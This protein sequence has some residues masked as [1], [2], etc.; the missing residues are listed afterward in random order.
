MAAN[1]I[2]PGERI[3]LLKLRARIVVLERITLAA[4]E[5]SLRVR[6]EELKTNIELARSRLLADYEDREF[7]PDITDSL[8]RAFVAEE[9]ERLMRGVQSDM[10]FEGGVSVP[11]NG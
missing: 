5:L 3:E 1:D 2:L 9:V 11:E 7:A 6:P 8:E 4:L 10:G